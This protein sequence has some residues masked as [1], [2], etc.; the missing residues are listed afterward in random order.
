M[1]APKM[2]CMTRN[3]T[4]EDRFHDRPHNSEAATKPAM[5]IRNSSR[6]PI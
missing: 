6:L 3:S 4:I 2:P 5:E 1:A